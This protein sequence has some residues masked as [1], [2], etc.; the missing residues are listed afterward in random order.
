MSESTQAIIRWTVLGVLHRRRKGA[1]ALGGTVIEDNART[2][3]GWPEPANMISPV[4]RSSDDY[5]R[6]VN[7]RARLDLSYEGTAGRWPR[8]RMPAS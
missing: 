3:A 1:G 6:G 5:L 4:T 8:C 7:F 2:H